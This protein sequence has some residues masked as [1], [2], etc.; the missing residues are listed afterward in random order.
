MI[1][2]Q[3]LSLFMLLM[4]GSGVI[5]AALAP[6]AAS[7]LPT[8]AIAQNVRQTVGQVNPSKPIQLKI[9]NGGR[10]SVTCRLSRPASNDRI[11]AAGD[12]VTFGNLNA[13]YLPP[14]IYFL[15]YPADL[16]IG[17]SMDVFAENNVVT[18]IIG[19]QLSDTPGNTAVTVDANGAVYLY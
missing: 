11:V 15:A 3:I 9:I 13:Q 1:K 19:A 7:A 4:A 18:I 16:D 6:V 2:P 14:P 10:A 5:P 8:D 12:T 17:L